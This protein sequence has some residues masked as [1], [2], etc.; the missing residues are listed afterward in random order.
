MPIKLALIMR[1]LTE[2]L[3]H[4]WIPEIMTG[5]IPEILAA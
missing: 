1:W 5:E 4:L 3:Q 2:I